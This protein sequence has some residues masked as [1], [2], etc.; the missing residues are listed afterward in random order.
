MKR[1]H[2]HPQSAADRFPAEPVTTG[3]EAGLG[4]LLKAPLIAVVAPL[5]PASLPGLCWGG[6]SLSLQPL[7]HSCC[8]WVPESGPIAFK[9]AVEKH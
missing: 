1:G 2:T 4:Y 3:K 7:S 6:T 9:D 8:A 5:T